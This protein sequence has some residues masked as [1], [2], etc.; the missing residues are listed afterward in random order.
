MPDISNWVANNPVAKNWAD[1]VENENRGIHFYERLIETMPTD[2]I[3]QRYDRT[4]KQTL[5][6]PVQ[7]VRIELTRI[8]P[9]KDV[10][11]SARESS[12]NALVF[13]YKD[14]PTYG[15]LDIQNGDKFAFNNMLFEVRV[16]Y[17]NTPG[18]I[19]VWVEALQ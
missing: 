6:L 17:P 16:V 5:E 15:T 7:R 19:Q 18:G 2:I 14:H 3:I 4:L 10:G 13:G 1:D 12:F 9:D 11:P 8:Q